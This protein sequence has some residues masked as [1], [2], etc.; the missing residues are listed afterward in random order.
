[1]MS[2]TLGTSNVHLGP[3][4]N[5][6]LGSVRGSTITLTRE[7]GALLTAFIAVFVSFAG[8]RIWKIAA[9]G[10]YLCLS[11]D[12]HQDGLFHQ[13]QAVLRNSSSADDAFWNLVTIAWAW[14]KSSSSTIRRLGPLA[15]TSL[16]VG[17]AFALAGVFSAQVS[18]AMGNAV[19]LTGTHCA[20]INYSSFDP[21]ESR[22]IKTP[23][24]AT[25]LQSSAQRAQQCYSTNAS[26]E[27][28]P[29]FVQPSLRISIITHASCPFDMEVCQSNATNLIVDTGLIDSHN[30][31]GIN[32]SPNERFS[33]RLVNHC[34]PLVI[35][36]KYSR[37]VGNSTTMQ[38]SVEYY[39]G[40]PS[41]QD[42]PNFTCEYPISTINVSSPAWLNSAFQRDYTISY[43]C[44]DMSWS[45]RCLA[46]ILAVPYLHEQTIPI[47]KP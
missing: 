37:V 35:D 47:L 44:C 36:G 33:F 32:S 22:T 12:S 28:C 16:I 45:E 21:T 24:L 19:L 1:M 14:R 46:D 13:R 40:E 30:D 41:A 2:A 20:G 27:D 10:I 15:L 31:L 34:A 29:T 5:W 42:Q 18:S 7:N 25:L 8:L 17:L 38:Q 11:T 6:S 39:Y 23:Y 43:V 9:F 4:V 26:S 3:W